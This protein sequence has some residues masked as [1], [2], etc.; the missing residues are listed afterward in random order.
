MRTLT[1]IC[2]LISLPICRARRLVATRGWIIVLGLTAIAAQGANT[3]SATGSMATAREY[4]TATLLPNGKV[5]VTGGHQGIAYFASAELY[6]PVTGTWTTTGSMA[7]VRDRHTATLLSNGKV[8]VT[9]GEDGIAGDGGISFASAELYDPATGTWTTTGSMATAREQHTA[10]LLS[11]GKVLVTGGGNGIAYLAS[12][13]LYDPVTGTWTTTGSMTT[14]RIDHTATLLS[15]GKVLVTGGHSVSSDLASAELYNPVTGT[16]TKTG[17]MATARYSHTATLLPN[18]TVLVTG[19]R[20]SSSFFRSA[21]LYHPATGTWT[22]TGSMATARAFHTATLLPNGKVLV[23][24]GGHGSGVV[25]GAELYDPATGTWT[26]TGSMTTVRIG[27]TATLL[28]NGT[29][30]VTGGESANILN[31]LASAELYNIVGFGFTPPIYPIT[32]SKPVSLAYGSVQFGLTN[33]SGLLFRVLASTDLSLS[34][35]NWSV[36]GYPA[37]TTSGQY[38]FI[39]TQAPNYP[40][41]FYRVTIP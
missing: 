27:H 16:W 18:G 35:T 39:D 22:K 41:R 6:D 37:E 13:E 8:L 3:F 7:A 30:L 10:T 32:L 36:L 5:L 40:Q 29:V 20:N 38:L 23:T 17:S 15:N 26:T 21:E 4:H 31:V 14:V 34:P 9:G 24:G 2:N 33:S 11:N 28:P 12:T 25:A 1:N 19:G